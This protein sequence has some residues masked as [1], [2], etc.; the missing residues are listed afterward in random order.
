MTRHSSH[1]G[2]L[3]LAVECLMGKILSPFFQFGSQNGTGQLAQ[4]QEDS[5]NAHPTGLVEKASGFCIHRSL[6]DRSQQ[7]PSPWIKSP[8]M[9]SDRIREGGS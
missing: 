6:K 5:A 1:K 8:L 2:G 9:K 3:Y 7:C 4:A